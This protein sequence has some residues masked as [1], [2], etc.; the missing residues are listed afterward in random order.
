ML[1]EKLSKRDSPF[2]TKKKQLKTVPKKCVAD[3]DY[4]SVTTKK[5]SVSNNVVADS[6]V[7]KHSH[8]LGVLDG[9]ELGIP[10]D[11]N[12]RNVLV[13]GGAGT[14]KT[15]NYIKSN[16]LRGNQLAIIIDTCELLYKE[17]GDYFREKGYKVLSVDAYKCD[18]TEEAKNDVEDI[19]NCATEYFRNNSGYGLG[20]LFIQ[21]DFNSNRCVNAITEQIIERILDYYAKN[22]K[23]STKHIHFYLDEFAKFYLPKI[24]L[25]LSVAH[26]YNIGFS[27]VVQ[28]VEQIMKI[29]EK[30]E[31]Y[32]TIFGNADIM[33]FTRVMCKT[34]L[35]F[36][37]KMVA[38][39]ENKTIAMKAEIAKLFSSYTNGNKQLIIFRNE[40]PI[41]CDKLNPDDYKR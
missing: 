27:L 37:G 35:D 20:Y 9:V 5:N 24:N 36:L 10:S 38:K 13:V 32:Q 7:L 28:T 19:V 30:N 25:Y 21:K 2:I 15:H 14:G 12:S 16:L 39:A 6:I 29:Y 4:F 40:K 3:S 23:A 1:F 17:Y 11:D 34:D 22:N 41:V 26:K 18:D 8:L 33:V 31:T